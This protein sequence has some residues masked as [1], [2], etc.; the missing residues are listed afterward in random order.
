MP[1]AERYATQGRP[2]IASPICVLFLAYFLAPVFLFASACLPNI[3]ASKSAIRCA[4]DYVQQSTSRI[5]VTACTAFETMNVDLVPL[6]QSQLMF[7]CWWNYLFAFDLGLG[8]VSTL[9]VSFLKDVALLFPS[10]CFF[11]SGSACLLYCMAT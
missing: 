6:C 1:F 2:L 3:K 4:I 8:L 11:F 10:T 7:R 5:G 9:A